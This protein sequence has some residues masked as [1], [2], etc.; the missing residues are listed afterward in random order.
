MVVNGGLSS[1]TV[2]CSSSTWPM[3]PNGIKELRKKAS[4]R[5]VPKSLLM[6]LCS[7]MS[8][9]KR[10]V[11]EPFLTRRIS[12]M[13][14]KRGVSSRPFRLTSLMWRRWRA[15][16]LIES[17]TIRFLRNKKISHKLR[18]LQVLYLVKPKKANF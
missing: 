8:L 4:A 1:R 14:G 10:E 9:K 3:L 18:D 11:F 5:L 6:F 12:P 13:S 7:K 16:R 17:C 15:G 2:F